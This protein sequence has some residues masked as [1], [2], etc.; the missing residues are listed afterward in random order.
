MTGSKGEFADG[1][2]GVVAEVLGEGDHGGLGVPFDDTVAFEGS[3]DAED[4]ILG[5]AGDVAEFVGEYGEKS[6]PFQLAVGE[7][8]EHGNLL[9]VKQVVERGTVPDCW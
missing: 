5:L 6:E 9:V 7:E 2:D 3:E 4:L 1:L 8:A